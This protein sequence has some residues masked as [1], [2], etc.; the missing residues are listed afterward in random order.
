VSERGVSF[1]SPK[2]SYLVRVKLMP[3][4]NNVPVTKSHSIDEN[5]GCKLATLWPVQITLPQRLKKNT[6]KILHT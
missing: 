4:N 6:E 3:F 2:L 1:E 5:T